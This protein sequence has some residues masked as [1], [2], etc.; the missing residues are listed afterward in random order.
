MLTL[1]H[2]FFFCKFLP[3][4]FPLPRDL[5]D[6]YL[7]EYDDIRSSIGGESLFSRRSDGEMERVGIEKVCFQILSD[8]STHS[9]RDEERGV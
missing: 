1:A 9:R 3:P 2:F 4:F 7:S 5:T 8:I 6:L